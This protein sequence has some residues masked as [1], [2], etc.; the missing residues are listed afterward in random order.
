MEFWNSANIILD[1][2]VISTTKID[3][4]HLV[5]HDIKVNQYFK[6]PKPQQTFTAYGPDIYNEKWFYPKVFNQGDRVLFYLKKIDD[7]YM[8][9]E[10]S[11]LATE[12]CSPRDMIGL[13]TL[14]GE[15]IGRGRPTLLFDPYQTCNGYLFPVYF[16]TDLPPTKQLKSGIHPEDVKCKAGLT[17]VIKYDRSPACV[18][19][20]TAAKLIQRGWTGSD[21]YTINLGPTDLDIKYNTAYLGPIDIPSANNQFALKF[22]S[23]TTHDDKESNIFFSPTS[24]FTAF[25]IAY[26]GARENTATE[27]QQVFGFETDD[28]KRRA[29]FADMQTML[30]SQNDQYRLVLANA[31]WLGD[32]FEPL[33]EYVDTARTYYDSKVE[34]VD[35]TSKEKS[36]DVINQWVKNKTEGKIEK[37]FDDLDPGTLF[38]ITNAIYF[39]GT[40]ANQFDKENT[41]DADFDVT[42]EKT[43]QVPMMLARNVMLNYSQTDEMEILE[44]PYQGDRLSMLILLPHDITELQ[45]LEESLTVENLSEWKNSLHKTNIDVMIPKFSL[46][47]DYDLIEILPEMGVSSMFDASADFGKMTKNSDGLYVYKAVHKAF[48]DVSEEGTEAAAATGLAGFESGPPRF[49]ADHPFIFLI[50]DMKSGQILFMGRVVNPSE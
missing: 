33:P 23:Q 28:S 44:M 6:N 8:I 49:V 22:Y 37:L 4:E 7:K 40:W 16:F 20:D 46:S 21:E 30:N 13:S 9:L 26:E 2:T 45:S 5:L 35:F 17:Q 41:H 1:G 43:V 42:S 48:V 24:L 19:L 39:N 12:K 29:G 38:A 47:T 32:N 34:S 15:S 3:S 31:L 11:V 25:A 10:Q 50:Q 27:M 18:K 14:P 36:L